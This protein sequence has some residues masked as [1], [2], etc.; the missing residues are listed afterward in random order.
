MDEPQTGFEGAEVP[1]AT[2]TDE[3]LEEESETDTMNDGDEA[4]LRDEAM[5]ATMSP[6]RHSTLQEIL[7]LTVSLGGCNSRSRATLGRR[8]RAVV[9]E[10]YSPPRVAQAAAILAD[11]EIDPGLS[12]DIT[13][14][15][16]FGVPWDFN[17]K[18]MRAKAR[19]RFD[20]QGLGLFVGSPMGTAYSAW[21]RIS[22]IRSPIEHKK[23]L[24]EARVHRKFVCELYELQMRR[25]KLLLHEHPDQARSCQV[26]RRHASRGC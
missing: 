3:V 4:S 26:G 21:Q 2:P 23:K 19:R 14:C 16:E 8:Y 17:K 20:E 5:S 13:T 24:R 25:G 7:A 6:I 22:K 9:L 15:D 11:L 12:L 10:V 18:S 1:V